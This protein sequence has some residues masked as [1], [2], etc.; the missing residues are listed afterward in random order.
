MTTVHAYTSDQSLQDLAHPSRKG[1]PDL[2]RMR[3]AA[4]SIIPN[5][6][7]AARAIGLVLP[8]LKGKL[9][10]TV[11]ARAHAHR[12]DHRPV[13]RALQERRRSTR[14]TPRSPRPRPTRRTAGC[15]STPTSRW[16]RPTSSATRRRASSRRATPWPT[17]P[18]SRCSAGTTTS[19]ATRTA[20]STWSRSSASSSA[21]T[22]H[23]GAAA[24]RADDRPGHAVLVRVDFN[25]PLRDGVVEDDLRITTAVPTLQWLLERGAPSSRAVTSAARRARPTR[26]TRWRRWRRASRS[27]SA[28]RCRSR[29]RSRLDASMPRSRRRARRRACCSRTSASTR[30]RRR[31]IPAFAKQP[32]HGLRRVRE[33]RVR[34]VAPVARSDRRP[35]ARRAERGRAAA[36]AR[37]RRAVAACSPSRTA[38]SSPSS[39]APRSATSSAV[40]D[41]L[42]ERCDTVLV[43]GAMAFTFLLARASPVGRLPGRARHGRGVPATARDRPREGPDRRRVAARYRRDAETQVVAADAMPDGWKGLDVGPGDRR[44]VPGECS[45]T[46]RPCCG[47]GR[48][49]CSR[50][51]RSRRDPCASPR[52]SP[53]ARASPWW[54]AATARRRS[55][56]WASPTGSSHVSTGGG[57]ALEL[58]EQGDLPGLAALRTRD[59]H[60]P[61]ARPEHDPRDRRTA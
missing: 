8:E 20:S 48:W 55:A 45:P 9:D 30:A 49:A 24:R 43:G 44:R 14:S 17:A 52:P 21:S 47:T 2:R 35:A 61:S 32:H 22:R 11:A 46:R 3:A 38:R 33:R 13:G 41:A 6:T 29:R 36:G 60:D 31:T 27:C 57:A 18:S 1:E 28:S 7:G 39:A 42:L 40:I 34:R 26:S 12:L 25:V 50:S 51:S 58:L 54:A 5:T 23:A 15:S 16:S 10:G 56:R 19:G 53:R 59:G 4:L 37:G